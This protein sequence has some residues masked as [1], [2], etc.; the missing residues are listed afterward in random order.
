LY[1]QAAIQHTDLEMFDRQM[2]LNLRAPFFLTQAFAARGKPGNVINIIDNKV[3]FNQNSYAAY[4]LTKKALLELTRM[5]AVEYAP[6]IRV[7]GVAPGLV[8]PAN[9]RSEDYLAW[10]K[11]GIPLRALGNAQVVIQAIVS[12]LDNAYIT[13]QVLT[14]DGGENIFNPGRGAG[15]YN[16]SK[17]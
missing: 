4:L 17:V 8:L 7:N 5:A 16:P 10:R 3:A 12:L 2:A 14:V 1:F 6:L 11:E 13:G 15:D 9:S